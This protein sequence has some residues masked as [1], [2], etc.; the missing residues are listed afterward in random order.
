MCSATA[1]RKPPV[2]TDRT[3]RTNTGGLTSETIV[4]KRGINVNMAGGGNEQGRQKRKPQTL[5]NCVVQVKV[6]GRTYWYGV[7]KRLVVEVSV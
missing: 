4:A 1:K 3:W 2:L 6:G 7:V 5:L